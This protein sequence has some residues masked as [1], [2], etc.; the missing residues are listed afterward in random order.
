[1][2]TQSLIQILLLIAAIYL[3]FFKSYLTEKGKSAALK[4][5]I[6][7]LTRE[8]ETVKDEFTREQEILK[9]DL[10]WILN[11]EISYRS[12]ERTALINFHGIVNEWLYSISEVGYGNYNKTNIDQLIEIRQRN[13]SFYSKAG[14][15]K[16]RITLLVEDDKLVLAAGELYIEALN[17]HHWTDMEF[18]KLQQ[19]SESQKSLTDR[20]LIIIKNLEQNRVIADDMSKEETILREEA[21]ALYDNYKENFKK[22]YAKVL[23]IQSLYESLVK[24]YLKK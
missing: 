8:V 3:A 18:F 12:E 13:A 5:D 11:N 24:K 4:E 15:S 21:K 7:E 14:I 2:E 20:F 1:M 23:P 6:Q 19:N 10:Q 22:E 9:T 16:A 17:F